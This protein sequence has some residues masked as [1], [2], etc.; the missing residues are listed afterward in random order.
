V[1]VVVISE[2]RV[3]VSHPYP[4]GVETRHLKLCPH[5]LSMGQT[6]SRMK[7]RWNFSL[8]AG[9]LLVLTGLLTYVPIFSLFPV[10]RD[11]PWVNLLLFAIGGVLL[12]A[13][14]KRAYGQPDLYR[15]KVFGSILAVL[16]LA[17]VT[18][19]CIGLLYIARQL[20]PSAAA[21]RAG[22][23]APEFTLP[24]QNGKA[25][26]LAELLSSPPP[27]AANAKAGGVLLIFYRGFW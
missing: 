16:S 17:G 10:T 12:V 3:F 1:V 11:F 19:F 6:T 13:G 20:P 18:F 5:A 22:Q 2:I 15:G 25:V 24:D 14:L 9:F 4:L 26:A 7:R 27:G 21:P 23:K 8:W